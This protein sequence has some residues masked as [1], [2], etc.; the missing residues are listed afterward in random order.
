MR[1]S[2]KIILCSLPSLFY[3]LEMSW[4]HSTN[5]TGVEF[6]QRLNGKLEGKQTIGGTNVK[7]NL[8]K[9][10]MMMWTGFNWLRRIR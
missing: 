6:I 2:S 1:E 8:K 5:G 9:Y 4:V 10:G 7:R 3:E